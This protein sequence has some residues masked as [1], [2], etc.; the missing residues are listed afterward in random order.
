MK[1]LS[2]I[3]V[4]CLADAFSSPS[5]KERKGEEGRGKISSRSLQAAIGCLRLRGKRREG[6]EGGKGGEEKNKSWGVYLTPVFWS[7]GDDELRARPFKGKRER[8]KGREIEQLLPLAG[9]DSVAG[10]VSS[11]LLTV[12]LLRKREK[13]KR[14]KEERCREEKRRS[15]MRTTTVVPVARREKEKKEKEK[16][17]GEGGEKAY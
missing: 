4:S 12:R 11:L 8:K 9:S 7:L 2:T 10:V 1:V 5:I 16:K 6:G 3:S 14:K 15:D 13:K 17:K